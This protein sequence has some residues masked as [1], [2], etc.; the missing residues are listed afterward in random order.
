MFRKK[1]LRRLVDLDF[2]VFRLHRLNNVF[3]G[4]TGS[5]FGVEVEIGC[6]NQV[7]KAGPAQDVAFHLHDP[8]RQLLVDG[9]GDQ[10]FGNLGR[11]DL[12]DGLGD[13]GI[14]QEIGDDDARHRTGKERANNPGHVASGD[15][16]IVFQIQWAA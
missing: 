16:N 5:L 1:A 6:L 13:I 7:R 2:E 14:G 9:G 10:F 4:L 11:N 12:H 3:K 8:L 15:V